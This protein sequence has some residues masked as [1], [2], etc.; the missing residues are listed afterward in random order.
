MHEATQIV[1]WPGKEVPACEE[2]AGKL[3]TL[4]GVMGFSLSATPIL[5]PS[6]DLLCT[7]CVN[8]EKKLA[9]KP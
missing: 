9:A 4:A 7:N 1:H 3:A 8:E 2:H 5:M 6:T